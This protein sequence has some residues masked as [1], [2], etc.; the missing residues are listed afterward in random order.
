[1]NKLIEQC[2]AS[3][4]Q[5]LVDKKSYTI[6][7]SGGVDSVVLLFIFY[8]IAQYT[9]IQLNAIHINHGISANAQ[10]WEQFC[11]ALCEQ[12]NVP[13]KIA[14]HSILRAGGESVE[15]NARVARYKDF[16]ALDSEVIVLGHHKNDQAETLLSQ[17]LRGSDLHNIASMR[18]VSEKR[19]KLFWRPLLNL[20]RKE[21]ENFAAEH[22]LSH[23]DDESN[24]DISYLRNFVRHKLFPEI[25]AWDNNALSKL[26]QVVSTIQE[27]VALTD[28]IAKE[29]LSHLVIKNN[30]FILDLEIF[31]LLSKKRQINAL[32]YLIKQHNLPLPS[33]K[34]LL[35]FCNQ[36][37]SSAWD[38]S[39]Q[40]NIQASYKLIKSKQQIKIEI[41]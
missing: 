2:I 5:E 13:L 9:P 10:M 3:W 4:P 14:K 38:K 35:E 27:S 16:C 17:I 40:L 1:M 36:A 31:K 19:G 6:A 21:I 11:V 28:E 41:Q 23:I 39:P 20:T 12:L 15:N 18:F 37:V 32:S 8:K 7:L 24:L 25:L 30:L 34:Q 33:K 26:M 22:Q 29:D